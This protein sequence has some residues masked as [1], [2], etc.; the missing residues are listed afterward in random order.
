MPYIDIFNGDADGILAL[1][2]LRLTN[3]QKSRLITGVKR[4]TKLL[5]HALSTH[6]SVITVLDI[7]SHANREPL[8]QLLN[9]RY[10]P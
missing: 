6:D 4:D 1:H 5:Q 10:K 9:H 3:P 7:S 2:Q 8:L